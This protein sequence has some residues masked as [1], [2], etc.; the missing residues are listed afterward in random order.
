MA[1]RNLVMASADQPGW[2]LE[3]EVAAP[4]ACPKRVAQGL[5]GPAGLRRVRD[6]VG[7]GGDASI[8]PGFLLE[9]SQRQAEGHDR[10]ESG[11]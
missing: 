9:M 8:G 10:I 5:P 3:L 6:D 4:D 7:A 11:A 1:A 2:R